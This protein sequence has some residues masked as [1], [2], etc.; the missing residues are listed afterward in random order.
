MTE[1]RQ[2]R[3]ADVAAALRHFSGN[4]TQAALHLGVARS[5][6]Y[7]WMDLWNL[8][9]VSDAS[10]VATAPSSDS[11]PAVDTQSDVSDK[12]DVRQSIDDKRFPLASGLPQGKLQG[13][14]MS[15]TELREIG[16]RRGRPKSPARTFSDELWETYAAAAAD[17]SL[18]VGH[19]V[20]ET[21]L[22]E[23][24]LNNCLQDVM[25]QAG[26]QHGKAAQARLQKLLTRIK[27][28]E[29]ESK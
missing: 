8:W 3:R 13:D 28:K 1:R 29:E 17:Y 10:D 27:D 11:V 20:T 25:R 7:R 26:E 23:L 6:L 2:H 21:E 5:T 12:S 19:P 15:I 24:V 14:E 9:D 16:R 22:A 4:I 18:L